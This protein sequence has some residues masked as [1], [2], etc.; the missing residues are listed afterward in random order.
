MEALA[1]RAR[2]SGI[3][4]LTLDAKRGDLDEDLR[5]PGKEALAAGMRVQ[6]VRRDV[7][8]VLVVETKR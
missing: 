2:E 6:L 3:G 8:R 7:A 5:R 4:A 1:T